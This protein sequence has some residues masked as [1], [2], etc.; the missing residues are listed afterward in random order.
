MLTVTINVFMFLFISYITYT[1]LFNYFFI[2]SNV[3][4]CFNCQSNYSAHVLKFIV[5]GCTCRRW[6]NFIDILC[7]V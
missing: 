6:K 4:I 3:R 7:T 2:I 1:Y 5:A